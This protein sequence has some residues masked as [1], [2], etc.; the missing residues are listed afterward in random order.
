[1][2]ERTPI[3][4]IVDLE[5][6]FD[7][8]CAVVSVPL[9]RI[10]HGVRNIDKVENLECCSE[11]YEIAN[12]LETITDAIFEAENRLKQKLGALEAHCYHVHDTLKAAAERQRASKSESDQVV[13]ALKRRVNELEWRIK[14]RHIEH[15]PN[16]PTVRAKVLGLTDGKCAYCNTPISDDQGDGTGTFAVEHVVP[17]SCGGPDHLTNFVPACPRCNSQKHAGHVV[18]FIRKRVGGL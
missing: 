7:L 16:S 11:T 5:E 8:L 18:E 3:K 17:K 1:M 6:W 15:N 12:S 4:E 2:T 10:Q 9:L 14:Q 13:A